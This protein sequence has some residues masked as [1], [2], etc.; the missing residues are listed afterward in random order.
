MEE[1]LI[2]WLYLAKKNDG[3][4]QSQ[5]S[6]EKTALD[7]K[8]RKRRRKCFSSSSRKRIWAVESENGKWVTRTKRSRASEM[9][10]TA[11]TTLAS[12]TFQR[13]PARRQSESFHLASAASS[14]LAISFQARLDRGWRRFL[15]SRFALSFKKLAPTSVPRSRRPLKSRHAD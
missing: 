13:F 6:K 9:T 11:T 8:T 1:Y 12:R 5:A 14:P 4:R 10:A 15:P 2:T 7:R 3:S